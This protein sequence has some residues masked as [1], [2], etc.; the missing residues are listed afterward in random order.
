MVETVVAAVVSVSM[1][2]TE[3]AVAVGR[4]DGSVEVWR[5]AAHR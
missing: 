5:R 3:D 1:A 4:G 2:G